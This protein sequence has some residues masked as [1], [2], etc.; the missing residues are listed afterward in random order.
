MDRLETVEIFV[1]VAEAG[2]F[3]GAARRLERAPAAM[4]RAVAALEDRLGIRLF[5]RTTRAV[6]LTDAGARYLD[7]ARRALTE[8]SELELSAAGE[9]Q[10]PRGVLTLTAPEMFGRLHMLPIVQA[11]MADYP[12]VDVSLLLLNRIVSYVD[13]G[14]DLGLRIAHLPDSSL[15]AILVGHVQRICCASPAY[16]EASGTP[17]GIQELSRHAIIA[18]TGVRPVADRWSFARGSG[19]VSVPIQPRLAVNS[20][21][22][23]LDAAIAG[24]GIVRL[25]SY[26]T[27]IAEAAGAANASSAADPYAADPRAR[28]WGLYRPAYERDSCG[29]GLIASLDDQPSHWVVQ[30]AISSLC[31]LTH[32]GAIAT[33]GKTGD[34]CGLLIK[35]P[36]RFLRA[37]ALEAQLKLGPQFAAGLVFLSPD[38]A[39]AEE[40]LDSL[41]ATRPYWLVRT[42]AGI[43][44]DIG[45]SL[46]VYNLMRTVLSAQTAPNVAPTGAVQGAT[47]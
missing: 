14:I 20:V 7:R 19:T 6:A 18:T 44:M 36:K 13:E 41:V 1:A 47:P 43:S 9:Q 30:T 2:S 16:L 21:Q 10:V 29:F 31:R 17:R 24:G 28:S 4:T 23:A 25:L 22:A 33:D 11:Y 12:E 39:K 42:T 32:R 34:G 40:W 8:F 26:Q 37:V 35:M 5:N 46:L 45:M 15:Q 38:P 27:A 3:V